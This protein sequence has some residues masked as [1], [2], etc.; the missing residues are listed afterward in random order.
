MPSLDSIAI[1]SDSDRELLEAAGWID[2]RELA[3]ADADELLAE[4][5]KANA[6]LAI[7][8]ETPGREAVL[9]WIEAAC[10]ELGLAPEAE[11]F[12]DLDGKDPSPEVAEFTDGIEDPAQSEGREGADRGDDGDIAV[13][14][15]VPD[16]PAVA[17]IDSGPVNYEA[18]P[19]VREMIDRSPVAIPLPN[20]M[21]AE[22]GI[23]PAEIP[24]APVLNRASGDLDVRIVAGLPKNESPPRTEPRRRSTSHAVKRAEQVE[25]PKR[26]LDVS[27]L[28][29]VDEFHDPEAPKPERTE[30]PDN[31]REER[32]NLL[33]TARPETNRGKDPNSRRFIRG[34][35]HDRPVLVWFGALIFLLLCL[36]VPVAMVAAVM[37]A[38]GAG[39]D[40]GESGF[41]AWQVVVPA[42]VPVFGV[43]Y[44]VVSARVK[45]RVC[46]Q[47]VLMPRQCL[48]NKKAHHIPGLGH[49]VPLA[50]HVLT[51]RWFNCTFCGTSIRIKE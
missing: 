8:A 18:E 39:S 36:V 47:R 11:T 5:S 31:E 42:L 24:A 44:L 19:E 32:L 51:F 16:E 14:D 17:P 29:S 1:L 40:G 20:R 25:A 21:L 3:K 35:L 46:G 12:A 13:A 15:E 22:R 49:I 37:L 26:E 28:R 33:R 38:L 4:V 27:R 50:L 2:P 9:A 45:C 48:K 41:P 34:V 10:E 6:M 30:E 7:A 23:A 43:L